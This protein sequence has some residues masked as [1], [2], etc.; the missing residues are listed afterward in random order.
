[1]LFISENSIKSLFL[2]SAGTMYIWSLSRN[3]IECHI[4]KNNIPSC[5]LKGIVITIMVLNA[6]ICLRPLF[7]S[8][9]T[10]KRARGF[11]R[12]N[13]NSQSRQYD[14]TIYKLS[15]ILGAQ[16]FNFPLYGFSASA[17]AITANLFLSHIIPSFITL[18]NPLYSCP[19]EI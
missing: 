17:L 11:F 4:K 18:T 2:Y 5:R 19:L 1:M 16:L 12:T 13:R 7:P 9:T 10:C 14:T 15:C 3:P 6:T 8:Y